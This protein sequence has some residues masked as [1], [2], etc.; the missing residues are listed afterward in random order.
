[1]A[2][3]VVQICNNALTKIGESFITS[4]SDDSKAARVCDLMYEIVRD[5]VLRNHPWNF[6]IER[7]VCA[8]LSTSPAFEYSHQYQLPTD[9]LRVLH[10]QNRKTRF[11]IEGRKVLT[12]SN[13]CPILYIKRVEDVSK[14]DSA[15]SDAVA[16]RLAVEL[17]YSI[18]GDGELARSLLAQYKEKLNLA[19]LVDAQEGTPDRYIS[20]A[21]TDSFSGGTL[22]SLGITWATES[23]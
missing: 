10:M 22:D 20:D 3:S 1:M 9:C 2:K 8:R 23:N 19:R 6:S 21:W 17:A 7:T 13:T 18:T 15:F 14:F 12:D 11:K 16:T 5:E 4:L